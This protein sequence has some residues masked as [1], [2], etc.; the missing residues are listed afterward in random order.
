MYPLMRIGSFIDL[1]ASRTVVYMIIFIDMALAG[2]ESICKADRFFL[3]KVFCN[4]YFCKRLPA[5]PF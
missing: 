4:L 5:L 1:P 2:E 3:S